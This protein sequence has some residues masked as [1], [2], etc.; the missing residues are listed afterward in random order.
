MKQELEERPGFRYSP[1]GFLQ[2]GG[3]WLGYDKNEMC[4]S[5]ILLQ[6]VLGQDF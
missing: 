2:V 4:I 3:I 5:P 1:A 6:P